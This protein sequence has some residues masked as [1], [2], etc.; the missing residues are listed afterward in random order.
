MRL[1]QWSEDPY[2]KAQSQ[3]QNL[4]YEGDGE[5][6]PGGEGG[7]IQLANHLAERG[8][9]PWQAVKEK[10]GRLSGQFQAPLAQAV[11]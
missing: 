11:L 6:A 10:M 1:I 7:L 3:I 9:V 2:Y 4:A 8:K 5:F